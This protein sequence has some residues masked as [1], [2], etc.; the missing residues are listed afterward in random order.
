MEYIKRNINQEIARAQWINTEWTDGRDCNANNRLKL[1]NNRDYNIDLIQIN[2]D[3]FSNIV[4]PAHAHKYIN[5]RKE[6]T[7]QN[8]YDQLKKSLPD[9]N[10]KDTCQERINYILDHFN[11][12]RNSTFLE[13]L[14]MFITTNLELSVNNTYQLKGYFTG[15]FHQFAAY[16]L[17]IIRNYFK[18]LRLYLI[19]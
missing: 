14:F 3:D 6:L 2:Q 8:L 9:T 16:A 10:V 19:Q 7:L 5:C 18:P 12:Y 1:F 17:W 4:L 11:S 13:G 15:S